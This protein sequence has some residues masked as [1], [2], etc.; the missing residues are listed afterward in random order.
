MYWEARISLISRFLS[1]FNHF[2]IRNLYKKYREICG[3]SGI[4]LMFNKESIWS[5]YNRI[6]RNVLRIRDLLDLLDFCRI[7]TRLVVR[8]LHKEIH[9]NMLSIRD[10][11]DVGDFV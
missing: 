10:L 3:E 8:D 11:L 1:I 2:L 9:R 4:S 7:V 5:K 6:W